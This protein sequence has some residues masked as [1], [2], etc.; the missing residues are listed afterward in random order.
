LIL[1][2]NSQFSIDQ[3]FTTVA[4]H[5]SDTIVD[6]VKLGDA[7][8]E[9]YFECRVGSTGVTANSGST[10]TVRLLASDNPDG[11][12]TPD[13]LFESS[14]LDAASGIAAGTLIALIRLPKNIAK[15]YMSVTYTVGTATLK[16]GK[17]NAYMVKD[18]QTNL[19]A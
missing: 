7:V 15:R 11:V 10:L 6:T 16:T 4:T 9:L 5:V 2:K 12:T 14:A 19:S 18:P 8:N 1:D 17:F 13:T 3:A